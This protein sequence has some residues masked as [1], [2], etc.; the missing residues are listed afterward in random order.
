MGR[1]RKPV[2]DRDGNIIKPKF[3]IQSI[4]NVEGKKVINL[5]DLTPGAAN[6]FREIY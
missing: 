1:D 5:R 4:Y 2:L 6:T 3:K